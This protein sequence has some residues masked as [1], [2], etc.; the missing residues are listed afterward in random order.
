M[1]TRDTTI[2]RIVL[3]LLSIS[4]FVGIWHGF[5]SVTTIADEMFFVGGVLRAIEHHTLLP[6]SGDVPYGTVTYLLSYLFSIP[7][8][9]G[10]FLWCGLSVAKMKLLLLTSPWIM[11]GAI[12]CMSASIGVF[13]V[14]FLN[15]FLR[16]IVAE[17]EV[18]MALL[19]LLFCTQIVNFI[20]HTG[21]V[22]VVST[23]LLV[24]SFVYVY[25]ALTAKQEYNNAD[26]RKYSYLAIIVSFV[27]FANLPIMGFALMSAPILC[28]NFWK[29]KELRL[30]VCTSTVV[31]ALVFGLITALN[32]GG[33]LAQVESIFGGYLQADSVVSVGRSLLLNGEKMVLLFP[34]ILI[35][36]LLHIRTKITDRRLFFLSALYLVL[37]IVTISAIARWSTT[38]YS[39]YRYLTPVGF[40]LV[41][42]LA[43]LRLTK[44]KMLCVVAVGSFLVS[45][46]MLYRLSIPDM[47]QQARTWITAEINR[48]DV[49]L[50]NNVGSTF[51]LPK[52]TR[53]YDGIRREFCATRCLA[54]Y[55]YGI[56]KSFLPLVIDAQ[57]SSTT[58]SSYGGSAQDVYV[59]TSTNQNSNTH[60]VLVKSFV[61][62]TEDA[63]NYTAEDSGSYFN[64]I[65]VHLVPF[66]SNVY[67]YRLVAG[68]YGNSR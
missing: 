60:L 66:G 51:E 19:V 7:V 59:L 46:M 52:N 11:Y 47:Y 63:P 15:R 17:V 68:V 53:S 57:T 42:L 37:Y 20:F 28:W 16:P 6:A 43:S 48:S 39:Y 8:L 24:L 29:N 41:L 61:N 58:Q 2:E 45:V 3:G 22:W 38:V 54:E 34:L 30:A 10:L 31:G 9:A 18:R 25:R 40:F 5:P 67:I 36:L 64:P 13:L 33:I 1:S 23:T 35:T 44:K 14:W 21:K 4:F 65:L 32:I 55:T 26:A 49:V 62:T 12:R 56:N 27:A 50:V